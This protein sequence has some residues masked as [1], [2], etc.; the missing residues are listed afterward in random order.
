M[1]LGGAPR[2]LKTVNP[3]AHR[4]VLE[5]RVFDLGSGYIHP[6]TSMINNNQAIQEVCK[7]HN[8][9]VG[10]PAQARAA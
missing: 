10:Q 6:Q 2:T 5:G 1:K 8:G 3:E 4:L 7:F 9:I